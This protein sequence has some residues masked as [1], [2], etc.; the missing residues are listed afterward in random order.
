MNEISIK[1]DRTCIPLSRIKE[2]T[3]LPLGELRKVIKEAEKMGKIFSCQDLGM[4]ERGYIVVNQQMN[5]IIYR[6]DTLRPIEVTKDYLVVEYKTYYKDINMSL[7]LVDHANINFYGDIVWN[8][9][10][11]YFDSTGN[12]VKKLLEKDLCPKNI[13]VFT[14][15]LLKPIPPRSIIS[16]GYITYYYLYPEEDYFIF[17]IPF[18]T[19]KLLIDVDTTILDVYNVRFTM[20][21]DPTS[22]AVSRKSN[23]FKLESKN[24]SSPLEI[25]LNMHI[26]NL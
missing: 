24:L 5:L 1:E 15:P 13:C 21:V 25:I 26:N 6:K 19:L 7:N 12:K 17:E 22:Y 23:R 3:N 14:I 2:K 4:N 18:P 11:Y 9:E 16:L 8:K 20:N 10:F